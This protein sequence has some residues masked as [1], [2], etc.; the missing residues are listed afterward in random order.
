MS[1]QWTVVRGKHSGA[2]LFDALGNCV[3]QIRSFE[4]ALE[5]ASRLNYDDIRNDTLR[6]VAGRIE[7]GQASRYDAIELRRL[8]RQ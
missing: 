6:L 8:I 4:L 2:L 1:G 5:M 7:S 3:A